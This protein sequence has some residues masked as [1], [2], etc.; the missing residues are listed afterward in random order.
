MAYVIKH[1]DSYYLVNAR[2]KGL[3]SPDGR[4]IPPGRACRLSDG[5]KIFSSGLFSSGGL[6]AVS[7]DT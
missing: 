7:I 1:S 5:D 4:I 3:C 6:I 2:V